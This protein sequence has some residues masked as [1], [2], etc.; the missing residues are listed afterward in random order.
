MRQ[1]EGCRCRGSLP[2][3]TSTTV[4]IGDFTFFADGSPGGCIHLFV[5]SLRTY[6]PYYSKNSIYGYTQVRQVCGAGAFVASVWECACARTDGPGIVH[7]RLHSLV[8]IIGE[9]MSNG[10]PLKGARHALPRAGKLN[11]CAGTSPYSLCDSAACERW[12]ERVELECVSA[13]PQQEE[14]SADE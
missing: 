4:L 14:E 10:A 7:G 11:V 9:D 2:S 8:K 12:D 3:V 13:H 6:T 5:S 1:W